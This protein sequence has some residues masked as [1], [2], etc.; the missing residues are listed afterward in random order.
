MQGWIKLHRKLLASSVFQN[1][2]ILKFW[3][4]CLLKASHAE[5]TT[6]IGLQEVAL[7]QGQFPFGRNAASVELNMNPSTIYKYL[8]LL[9]K[10]R[11]ISTKRNNKFTIVTVENWVLYQ[12]DNECEEQQNNNNVT[13]K[14]QQRNTNKNVKNDKNVKKDIYSVIPPELHDPVKEFIEHRKNIKKKMSDRAIELMMKKLNELSKGDIETSKKILE[15][16]ILSGWAGVF[17]LKHET[18]GNPYLD[19]LKKGQEN[20]HRTDT[21]DF[22]HNQ[23]VFSKLLQKPK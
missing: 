22:R 14:E 5:Y 19:R 20:E 6:R 4:W 7:S 1:P 15:Q 9:E 21:G 11:L 2:N 17:P 18:S 16:S 10:E 3:V 8:N 13:T 23:D 12:G